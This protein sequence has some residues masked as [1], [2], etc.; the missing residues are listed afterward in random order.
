M[1]DQFAMCLGPGTQQIEFQISNNTFVG[2]GPSAVQG[3]R[4]SE[5]LDLRTVHHWEWMVLHLQMGNDKFKAHFEAI[6]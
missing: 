3:I 6:N 1:P 4:T 2:G 5:R